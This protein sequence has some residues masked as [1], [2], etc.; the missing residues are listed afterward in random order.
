MDELARERID[1]RYPVAEIDKH[2][3]T[4][5]GPASPDDRAGQVPRALLPNL[6]RAAT[7]LHAGARPGGSSDAAA[8]PVPPHRVR[9]P[10]PS[11]SDPPPRLDAG[12]PTRRSATAAAHAARQV[13]SQHIF[14]LYGELR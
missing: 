8:A 5:A 12:N 6:E 4:T 7:T 10:P 3:L 14:D 13:Q 1:Q 9:R 2:L 11:G